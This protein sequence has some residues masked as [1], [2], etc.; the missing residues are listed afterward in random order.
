MQHDS[1][2]ATPPPPSLQEAGSREPEATREDRCTGHRDI[3]DQS[4]TDVRCGLPAGD[5]TKE[6]M[7]G[8]AVTRVFRI[9]DA[10]GR[11]PF[12]PGFSNRWTDEDFAPGMKPMPPWGDEFGWD[13]I[14]RLGY[15]DE[16]F[17]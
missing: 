8:D 12:K 17:G 11:G 5:G 16:H 4:G 2:Q 1:P 9:Q 14:E 15:P 13:L 10:E 3:A 6:R 7:G